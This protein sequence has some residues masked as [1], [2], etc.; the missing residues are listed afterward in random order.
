[1]RKT[2]LYIAVTID[3]FIAGEDDQ[4]DWLNEAAGK[5][6]GLGEDY[7]AFYEEVET[8]IM[9]NSTYRYVVNAGVPNPYPD[10]ESYVFTTNAAN[11]SEF[12]SYITDSPAAFV[13][14]LKTKEGGP[15]WVVGGGRING[16]L[17]AVDMID[18]LQLT[19]VPVT[20][21]RG[22]RLFEGNSDLRKYELKE[23]KIFEN[24]F[25]KLVYVR[26]S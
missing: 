7:N 23:T 25:V 21:G 3:G 12:V 1:M 15:I 10:K 4:L 22:I 11:E 20:L 6:D 2:I 19:M 14:A 18:E 26:S 9:G 5:G 17:L 24:G 8:V 13:E 16:Q